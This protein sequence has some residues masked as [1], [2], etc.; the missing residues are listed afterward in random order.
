MI[1]LWI[2][3]IML[4][5][6]AE[7]EK[8]PI[9]NIQGWLSGM[10]RSFVSEKNNK[11]I[12]FMPDFWGNKLLVGNTEYYK[13]YC[14]PQKIH[15]QHLPNKNIKKILE[16]IIRNEK[17]DIIHV[18]GTE[19]PNQ[20]I[21]F[22]VIDEKSYSKLVVS[23]QGLVHIYAKHF[24]CG[25]PN[26][27]IYRFGIKEILKRQNICM[28]KK[29]FIKRGYYEKNILRKSVNVI[30]RTEWDY[31][32]SKVVNPN[33]VY[34]NCNETLREEFYNDQWDYEKCEKYRIFYSSCAYPI[35]GFHIMLKALP[36][37]IK[38]YPDTHI[39]VT[40][41]DVKKTKNLIERVVFNDSYRRY[42]NK[43]IK[44]FKMCNNVTFLGSLNA[45]QMKREYL[46]CN[47]FVSA[48]S[49]ENSPNSVGEAMLLG[50][51]VIASYVGGMQSII[52]H[53][54]NGILFQQ[55]ADYML[56]AYVCK[57]FSDFEFAKKLGE[58]AKITAS[59]R[60]DIKNNQSV[61]KE[62]YKS[63]LKNAKNE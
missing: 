2:C 12:V 38:E 6:V 43:L 37:I 16:E 17:P 52:E 8:K 40:G 20:S 10:A 29:E 56:S 33:I 63:I 3:E 54:K 47:V 59:R 35:K 7:I 28:Q 61:L 45:E 32:C 48:S 21:I 1:I 31:N 50:T 60:H 55:E 26:N 51:P 24:Y 49:I 22:D 36:N 57:L 44:K 39:Y 14:Y 42:I 11:L 27:I 62:I 5:D 18:W 23:I 46:K 41:I 53:N 4:P 58:N 30:G 9:I 25:I 19:Y 34:Y 13:Y 15:R